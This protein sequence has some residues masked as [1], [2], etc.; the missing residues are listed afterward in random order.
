MNIQLTFVFRFQEDF[1]IVRDHILA[2]FFSGRSL[3]L[4]ST[5]LKPFFVFF[6]YQIFLLLIIIASYTTYKILIYI[7]Y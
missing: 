2:F 1:K 4:T 3:Y 5:F 7:S 6:F